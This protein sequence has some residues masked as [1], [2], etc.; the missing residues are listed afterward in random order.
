MTFLI[1]MLYFLPFFLT[2]FVMEAQTLLKGPEGQAVL[3]NSD[4]TWEDVTGLFLSKS[5][6]TQAPDSLPQGVLWRN[7]KVAVQASE[8][9]KQL[10]VELIKLRIERI[11]LEQ[12]ITGFYANPK[13]NTSDSLKILKQNYRDVA[14][15]EEILSFELQLAKEWTLFLGKSI[16]LNSDQW[17]KDLSLWAGD[18]SSSLA[19]IPSVS[20]NVDHDAET[21]AQAYQCPP[22]QT[23][24]I[25]LANSV[26]TDIQPPL[27]FS[28]TATKLNELFPKRDMISG[29]GILNSGR[30]GLIS[31]EMEYVFTIP[32]AGTQFGPLTNG[33]V[34]EIRLLNG[35]KIR[36]FNS[37][38]DGGIWQ[39][40]TQ[41]YHYRGK[42]SIGA[43][44]A[45]TLEKAEVVEVSV[46]WTKLIMDFEVFELDFFIN[47]LRCLNFR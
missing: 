39:A 28:F 27:L 14:A 36:L 17:E 23:D 9:E 34:L 35:E 10:S 25:S 32:N 16:F 13:S 21:K 42:Y 29:Y 2:T 5:R 3:L 26:Q 30:G 19:Y 4:G 41:S 20:S 6:Y 8:L 46:G 37:V 45:K 33:S 11:S 12:A 18:K 7:F 24:N 1:R 22:K 44:D 38:Y 15:K 40:K 31:F 43:R 47:Q